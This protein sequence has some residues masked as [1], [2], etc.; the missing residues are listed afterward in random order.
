[1]MALGAFF[2]WIWLPDIQDG[3]DLDIDDSDHDGASESGDT[4]MNE[5]RRASVKVRA[6]TWYKLKN[7]KLE[8]LA[9]GRKLA[10]WTGEAGR[11]FTWNV[12]F[13]TGVKTEVR[14][15]NKVNGS[16]QSEVIPNCLHQNPLSEKRPHDQNKVHPPTNNSSSGLSVKE[17]DF[18]RASTLSTLTNGRFAVRQCSSSQSVGRWLSASFTIS[19]NLSS[20]YSLFLPS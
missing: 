5:N 18:Q 14:N 17:T 6:M 8:V 3:V 7:K 10:V 4:R 20:E 1:M 13:L 9:E 12:Y 16:H 2:A 11:T 19:Y 15:N